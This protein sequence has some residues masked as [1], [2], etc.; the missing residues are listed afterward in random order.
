MVKTKTRPIPENIWYRWYDWLI[1]HISKSMKK[2][3]SSDKQMCTTLLQS[4]KDKNI[5]ADYLPRTINNTFDRKSVKDEKSSIAEYFE[6]FRPHLRDLIDDLKNSSEYKMHVTMK[7][8]FMPSID[9]TEKR[10]VYSKCGSKMILTTKSSKKFLK[11]L[12]KEVQF[13]DARL[14]LLKLI[15][16]QR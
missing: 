1:N 16:C 6:K 4:K 14:K 8:K 12:G 15:L 13:F 11:I 2:S 5:P 10:I 3:G 9:D 7:L